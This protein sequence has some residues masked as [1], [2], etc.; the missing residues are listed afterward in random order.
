MTNK[1]E[2]SPIFSYSSFCNFKSA[3]RIETYSTHRHV[4]NNKPR[5]GFTIEPKELADG[6]SVALSQG[7]YK[8]SAQVSVVKQLRSHSQESELAIRRKQNES[9]IAK[10]SQLNQS[11][12]DLNLVAEQ[13]KYESANS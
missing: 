12:L 1:A 6:S 4:K 13:N 2:N 9:I 5:K 7:E 11:K 10:A 3:E 8:D